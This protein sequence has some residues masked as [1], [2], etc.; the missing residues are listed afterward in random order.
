MMLTILHLIREHWVRWLLTA[1][2]LTVGFELLLIGTLMIRFE[3]V[4]NY[5]TNYDLF[6]NYQLIISGTPDLHDT[7][8]L[9]AAEPWME[10]GYKAPDYYGIAEWSLML[11]PAKLL[12]IF[13]VSLLLSTSHLLMSAAKKLPC[14]TTARRYAFGVSGFGSALLYL[15]NVTAT[16]VVCC[17]TPTWVVMFTMLGLSS[18][19]ALSIQPFGIAVG[20]IAMVIMLVAILYQARSIQLRQQIV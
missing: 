3:A 10:I 14:P 11:M 15:T 19:V 16:W 17:A 13:V 1:V 18:S 12:N 6:G 4:P 8:Q 20:G 9:L 7:L 5:L 2:V